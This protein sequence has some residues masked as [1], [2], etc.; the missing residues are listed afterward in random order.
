MT[1]SA[2]RKNKKF[3]WFFWFA[4]LIVASHRQCSSLALNL[5]LLSVTKMFPLFHCRAAKKPRSSPK[6]AFD[7]LVVNP[8]AM[9]VLDEGDAYWD[10]EDGEFV[11]KL[12]EQDLQV[13]ID[14]EPWAQNPDLAMVEVVAPNPLNVLRNS[15]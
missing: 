6:S 3:S 9:V 2:D 14:D 4:A 15:V 7:P 8:L 10:L 13:D 12:M 5:V 1:V 11:P